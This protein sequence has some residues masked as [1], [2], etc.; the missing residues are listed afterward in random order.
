MRVELCSMN[1]RLFITGTS[2]ELVSELI[3]LYAGKGATVT[4][5]LN[6]GDESQRIREVPAQADSQNQNNEIS[7]NEIFKVAW[8]RRSP[9]SGQNI[10]YEAVKFMGEIDRAIIIY[11][12]GRDNRAFHECSSGYIEESVDLGIKGYLF[13]LKEL[14]GYFQKK[15][16]GSLSLVID[17]EGT[18]ILS[19]VDACISG[20]FKSL[21]QSLFMF[22]QNE[23]IF[24]NGFRSSSA[25][26][27]DYAQFIFRTLEEKQARTKGEWHKFSDRSGFFQTL[28][29]NIK[30][31]RNA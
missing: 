18:D 22:Y 15:E 27:P 20:S 1:Q 12:P 6:T 11:S 9:L 17:D 10:V 30:K 23:P 31:N 24:I 3:R 21:A 28:P 13:L 7:K 4:V 26:I 8:N 16:S 5:A 14:I 19:P 25:N 29:L 2:P